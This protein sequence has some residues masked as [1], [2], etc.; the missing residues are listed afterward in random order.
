[1]NPVLLILLPWA[2]FG[3]TYIIRY[4][5]GPFDLF[6]KWRQFMGIQYIPIM[7][8]DGLPYRYEEANQTPNKFTAKLVKCFW[9][10]STWVAMVFGAL[11]VLFPDS[12]LSLWPIAVFASVG[13]AGTVLEVVFKEN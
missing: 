5:H 2:V 1:M 7:G 13:I 4:T 9:C 8:S 3:F 10:L 11:L 12:V 6:L